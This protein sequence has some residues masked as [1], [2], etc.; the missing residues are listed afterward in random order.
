MCIF[1]C[2]KTN[3]TFKQNMS[4]SVPIKFLHA[5]DGKLEFIFFNNMSIPS[6]ISFLKDQNYKSIRNS[7]INLQIKP[8]ASIARIDAFEVNIGSVDAQD[9]VDFA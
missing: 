5:T 7:P 9:T 2:T 3:N 1:D 8:F 6:V 4:T